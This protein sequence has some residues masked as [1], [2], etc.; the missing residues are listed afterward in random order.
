MGGAVWRNAMPEV[1]AAVDLL[2]A[3]RLVRLSWKGKVLETRIGPYR[4]GRP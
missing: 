2:V 3:E 1:H 4:I